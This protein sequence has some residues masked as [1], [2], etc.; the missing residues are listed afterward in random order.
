MWEEREFP[1]VRFFL[2]EDEVN[3]FAQV[4]VSLFI[5]PLQSLFQLRYGD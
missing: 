1:S 2:V 3:D 5:I 4:R